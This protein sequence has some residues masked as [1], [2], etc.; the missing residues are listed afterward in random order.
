MTPCKTR[1]LH[2]VMEVASL[3]LLGFCRGGDSV[4]PAMVAQSAKYVSALLGSCAVETG[5]SDNMV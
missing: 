2:V 1:L 4:R 3:D 5:F